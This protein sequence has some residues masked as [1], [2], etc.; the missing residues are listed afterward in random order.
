MK[1]V[2]L[3]FDAISFLQLLLISLYLLNE[4]ESSVFVFWDDFIKLLFLARENQMNALGLEKLRRK[5][6]N[7]ISVV[8]NGYFWV[9]LR[10][11]I[12]KL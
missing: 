12:V 5:I 6:F 1:A 4:A 8:L 3:R 9:S 7:K 11:E 10:N 2:I